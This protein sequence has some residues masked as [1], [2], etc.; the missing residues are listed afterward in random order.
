MAKKIIDARGMVCPKPLI[1]TKKALK[2]LTVGESMTVL[3][4][5][6]T[7]KQNVKRFLDDNHARTAI[8]AA[9]GV[10]RLN[11][12]KESSEMPRPDA[13]SYC[14]APAQPH[15]ICI[16]SDTMGSGNEELGAILIKAFINTIKET[17]P[18][19]GKIVFY[20][21][22]IFLALK[23]A[24]VCESLRELE[25]TGVTILVCGTCLDY[26]NKKPELGVGAISNMYD[27][28]E[29]MSNAGHIITP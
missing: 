24:P 27:I 3:I 18:L 16:R 6:E 15:V 14:A 23:S 11:V 5:N 13:Q 7:S 20:N 29:T 17:S 8:A 22:G 9:E 21:R 28:L 2:E 1:M 4:D 26:F 12:T 19:P 25:K 10:F